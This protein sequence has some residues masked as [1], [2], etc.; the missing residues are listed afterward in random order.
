[1]QINQ[2]WTLPTLD[3]VMA[4]ASCWDIWWPFLFIA[5]ILFLRGSFHMRTF[6]IC[7]SLCV[8]VTDGLVVNQ[9]KKLVGRPRPP[10]AIDGVRQVDLA[11]GR[12]RLL[13]VAKPLQVKY[14]QASINPQGGRSFPSGHTA[15]IFCVATVI[16]VFYRRWGW[17]AY[18]PAGLITYSR[19]YVGAHWPSDVTVSIF[20]AIGVTLITL[21]GINWLWGKFG[22]YCFPHW[23]ANHPLL[24]AS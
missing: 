22:G 23:H 14:S 15:N 12:P 9:L 16:F 5:A 6:L 2:N 11:K 17:L 13:S 8:I 4:V 10:A 19:I 21:A 18:L 1:M 20:L 3:W 24:I 7:C